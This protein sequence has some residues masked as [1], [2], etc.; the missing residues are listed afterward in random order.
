MSDVLCVKDL[1]GST[2][3]KSPTIHL[4][5]TSL[6][7]GEARAAFASSEEKD[8]APPVGIPCNQCLSW[9]LLGGWWC[10]SPWPLAT[11]P[12]QNSL[13]RHALL[14][15]CSWPARPSSS[16]PKAIGAKFTFFRA[17]QI[18]NVQGWGELNTSRY[19]SF[20]VSPRFQIC[21]FANMG[22]CSCC[23]FTCLLCICCVSCHTGIAS[24]IGSRFA[25]NSCL[26]SQEFLFHGR[27]W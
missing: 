5:P 21:L 8:I 18:P 22:G 27:T 2:W 23:I 19:K 24:F 9:S 26:T 15:P 6:S 13:Q 25:S 12:W 17:P 20:K 7:C 1:I 14:Q 16:N 11:H 3:P 4:Q 10:P